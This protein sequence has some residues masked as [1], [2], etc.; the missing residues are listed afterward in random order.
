MSKNTKKLL[1]AEDFED[2]LDSFKKDSERIKYMKENYKDMDLAK[3]FETFYN[4]KFSTATKKSKLINQ[5][6]C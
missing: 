3:S 4:V 6:D 1:T 5:K 2:V